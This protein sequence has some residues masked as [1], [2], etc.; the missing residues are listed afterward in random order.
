MKI[1]KLTESQ[2]IV[3][4]DGT[5]E[6][7]LSRRPIVDPVYVA[8]MHEYEALKAA[9]AQTGLSKLVAADLNAVHEFFQNDSEITRATLRSAD[10]MVE[11]GM[12]ADPEAARLYARLTQVTL[13]LKTHRMALGLS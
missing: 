2:R 1:P 11:E 4:L 7:A 6:R 10:Q 5:P 9:F 12:L 3:I 8:L 13:Q